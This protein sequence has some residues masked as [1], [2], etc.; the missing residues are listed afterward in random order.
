MK[1]IRQ[2]ARQFGITCATLR[3]YESLG[4]LDRRH[5]HRAANGYRLFTSAAEDRLELIRHG[6]AAGFTLRELAKGVRQWE[7]GSLTPTE[8]R[9]IF[10]EQKERIV[11]KIHELEA[12]KEYIIAKLTYLN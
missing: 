5:V 7:D 2:L 12:T 3:H 10:T 8:K 11:Q 6:K 9:D 4:L 1:T